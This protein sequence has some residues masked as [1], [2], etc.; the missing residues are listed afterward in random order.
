MRDPAARHRL[1]NTRTGVPIAS[2]IEAALD[3]TTRKRG[4]LGRTGLPS[5]HALVIAPSNLVHTFFMR[6]AI[7]IVFVRRDGT[8][9]K[10]RRSV[11][12]RRIAGALR[13]FAVIEMAA[14]SIGEADLRRGDRLELAPD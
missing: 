9:V 13:A 14:G 12:A 11:P 1:K 10:V 4:L 5:G 8:V 6:F 7:D 3:R 2:H